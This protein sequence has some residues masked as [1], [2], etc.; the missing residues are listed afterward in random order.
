MDELGIFGP[1]EG[2]GLSL[3]VYLRGFAEPWWSGPLIGI[4]EIGHDRFGPWIQFDFIE[5]FAH[6]CR[7]R[8]VVTLNGS[9]KASSADIGGNQPADKVAGYLMD[10]N[11]FK[12]ASTV[13]PATYPSGVSRTD[14]GAWSVS[15]GNSAT[16]STSI[17]VRVEHGRNLLEQVLAVLGPHD[18]AVTTDETAAGAFK[19]LIVDGY[20]NNDKKNVVILAPYLQ[21]A[22]S[23]RES[24]DF[25]PLENVIHLKGS[26]SKSAQVQYWTRDVASVGNHGVFEGAY[27]L[28]DADFN[29]ATSGALGLLEQGKGPDHEFA[30]DPVDQPGALFGVDY[31]VRDLVTLRSSVWGRDVT[32]LVVGA[33]LSGAGRRVSLA[34]E[35]GDPPRS[36]ARESYLYEGFRGGGGLGSR[37]KNSKG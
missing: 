1:L 24:V 12:S 36:A 31:D 17:R 32:R 21:T 33:K 37:F 25:S 2:Y 29:D 11:G 30:V 8:L 15:S 6:F 16:S 14:F 5:W 4:P 18:L 3:D 20:E 10:H 27:T 22:K 7:R 23:F 13:T 19:F 35:L 34:L 9:S 28:Q 26:G